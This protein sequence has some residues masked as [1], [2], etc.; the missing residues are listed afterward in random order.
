[1]TNSF[2]RYLASGLVF[3]IIMSSVVLCNRYGD[4]IAATVDVL[5]KAK[6]NLMNVRDV[7]R[8]VDSALSGVKAAL[9]SNILS[10]T[11]EESLFAGLDDLKSR[12]KDADVTVDNTEQKSDEIRLPVQIRSDMKNYTDFV[13]TVGYLQSLRFPF[14]SITNISLTQMQEK[15]EWASVRYE[16]K[17]ALRMPKGAL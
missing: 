4:S 12:M 6:L 14:F 1:M 8:A 17:G 5:Q 3:T 2:I 16:I 9:P 11:P 7:G 13:N 15:K 10:G